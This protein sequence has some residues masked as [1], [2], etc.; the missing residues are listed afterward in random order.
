MKKV[1]KTPEEAGKIWWT[2]D[3]HLQSRCPAAEAVGRWG[4]HMK[5]REVDIFF[6]SVAITDD[7]YMQGQTSR[8]LITFLPVNVERGVSKRQHRHSASSL[9]LTCKT[10]HPK[11]SAP[12]VTTTAMRVVESLEVQ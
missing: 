3:A 7:S 5:R 9:F 11:S 12:T 8:V 6:I 1:D 2:S 10:P 4:W